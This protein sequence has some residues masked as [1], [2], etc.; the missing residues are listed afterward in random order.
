M[1]KVLLAFDGNHYSE[2][3]L[4]F[5]KKLNE[6]KPILLTAAFLPQI[7]FANLWS[8][9]GGGLSGPSF[10][11]LVEDADA[12]AVKENIL[13]FETYCRANGIRFSVHK[14]YFDFAL[15]QL[16]KETRYADLLILSSELFYEQA[17]THTPNEYLKEALHGVECPVLVVPEK[18]EFPDSNILSYDGSESSVYAIK[19]F[20]YLFPEFENNDTTLI[21][22]S[23]KSTT[24]LPEESNINELADRHF[25][26]FTW[27]KLQANPTNYF[28]TWLSEKKGVILVSGSF[29]RSGLSMMLHKSFITDV[30]SNHRVPV[31]VAHK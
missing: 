17:G 22:V 26:G 16:K 6:K 12:D 18:F 27:L 10:I 21:Y 25:P 8:Y 1:K 5:A 23:E 9:S 2:G 30:I 31:F 13:R 7:D 14:D 4:E 11:P 19:Q 28:G 3:A 15:P 29:G 24:G 20:A